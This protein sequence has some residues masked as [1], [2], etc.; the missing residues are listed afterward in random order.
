MLLWELK[1]GLPRPSEPKMGECW[2][3]IEK[4]GLG[5]GGGS[6]S[7]EEAE[8]GFSISRGG[9]G[10]G[11]ASDLSFSRTPAVFSLSRSSS[12]ISASFS[13]SSRSVRIRLTSCLRGTYSARSFLAFSWGRLARLGGG[14]KLYFSSDPYLK[15]SNRNVETWR[16][17]VTRRFYHCSQRRLRYLYGL[18]LWT[19]RFH[20]IVSSLLF[21]EAD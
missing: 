5:W 18:Y 17:I 15:N 2:L 9:M 13:R 1:P 14:N 21:W 3:A 12:L 16:E 10:H 11:S 6:W 19:T 8:H 7:M 4:K 20:V